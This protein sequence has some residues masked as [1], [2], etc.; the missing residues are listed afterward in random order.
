MQA[1]FAKVVNGRVEAV[2][3]YDRSRAPEGLIEVTD[4]T[5]PAAVGGAWDGSTFA[6]PPKPAMTADEARAKRDAL[7]A[8][9]DWTQLAD[10]AGDKAAWAAYRQALRDVP[11]QPGFPQNIRWPVKPA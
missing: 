4:A 3:V 10:F 8:A 1:R 11:T 7:L 2:Q 6:P 5:G 9:S